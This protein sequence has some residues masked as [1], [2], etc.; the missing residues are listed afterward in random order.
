MCI[1]DTGGFVNQYP[2]VSG[3][4]DLVELTVSRIDE[5]V[6]NDPVIKILHFNKQLINFMYK[7]INNKIHKKV[8]I[9]R[10]RLNSYS[11]IV[12]SLLAIMN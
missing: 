3:Y 5:F 4:L 12:W 8:G 1:R 2:W 6:A 9:Y 7:L 10:I 11:T